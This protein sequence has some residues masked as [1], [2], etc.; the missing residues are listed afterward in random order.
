MESRTNTNSD[1]SPTKRGKA[2]IKQLF[3]TKYSNE[4]LKQIHST[5]SAFNVQEIL[6]NISN[7][8]I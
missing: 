3:A 1:T 4:Q 2:K 7:E 6:P 8:E 5:V